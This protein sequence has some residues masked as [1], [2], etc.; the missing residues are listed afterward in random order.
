M[1]NQRKWLLLISICVTIIIIIIA[2]FI[3]PVRINILFSIKTPCNLFAVDW[4]V[5]DAF[6]Y[7]NSIFGGM[8]TIFLGIITIYQTKCK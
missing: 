7:F 2:L 1:Y 8:G 4:N 5:N 6:S 3:I